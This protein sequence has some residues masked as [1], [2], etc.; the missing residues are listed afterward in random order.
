M[1]EIQLKKLYNSACI[2]KNIQEIKPILNRKM[3]NLDQ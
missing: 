3:D 2:K 1:S